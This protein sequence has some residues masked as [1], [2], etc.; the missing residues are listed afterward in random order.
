MTTSK[1]SLY[2]LE[3]RTALEGERANVHDRLR[4]RYCR[5]IIRQ[6]AEIEQHPIPHKLWLRIIGPDGTWVTTRQD[7]RGNP[8]KYVYAARLQEDLQLPQ[9]A[10]Y[11]AR[12]IKAY[13]D[14]LP[15]DTPVVLYRN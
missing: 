14:A 5:G 4:I 7:T 15:G 11:R 3:G 2:F 10:D 1:I 6:L 9:N 8:L 13:I 12:A